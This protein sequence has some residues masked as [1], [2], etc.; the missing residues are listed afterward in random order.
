MAVYIDKNLCKGCALCVARCPKKVFEIS[1][2][3]NRKGFVVAAPVREGNC[4]RC[5]L[6]EKT[7]PDLAIRVAPA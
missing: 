1:S 4:V 2:E 7:C 3:V 5:A 6:C